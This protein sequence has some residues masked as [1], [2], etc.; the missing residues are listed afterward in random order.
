MTRKVLVA[1]DDSIASV[2]AA[3]F[4]RE[5]FAGQ[6]V[7]V[8]AIS[9]TPRP[10]PWIAGEVGFGATYPYLAV[11]LPELDEELEQRAEQTVEQRGASADVKLAEVGD[12]AEAIREA[13]RAHRVSVIVVGSHQ[14]GLFSRLL[15]G[16]VGDELVHDAPCPVLVVGPQ[17]CDTEVPADGA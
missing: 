11:P 4:A 1:I 5:L 17:R 7:E 6:E 14:R 16:S 3:E 13:A 2:R 8:I 15:H 12:P 10:T 9:V